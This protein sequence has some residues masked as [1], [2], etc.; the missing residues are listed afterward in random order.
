[1]VRIPTHRAPTHPGE[2]LLKEFLEPMKISQ[3]ALAEGIG[4]TFARVNELVNGKRGV[5]A[6]TALRLE[7]FF[8]MEAQ[9]WM[10]LQ[11]RWD[12]YHAAHSA[13]AKEI[14]K[15]RRHAL[16]PATAGLADARARIGRVFL[17]DEA[18][19]SARNSGRA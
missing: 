14:A 11:L 12:L 3:S 8:G 2:M 17:K 15:I 19:T 16:V 6:E 1:M 10:N 9:F 13:K 18:L 7:R 4:V 5:T